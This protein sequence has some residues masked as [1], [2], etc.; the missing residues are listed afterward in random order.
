MESPKVIGRT[1]DQ[2]DDIRAETAHAQT[3]VR[4]FHGGANGE[5]SVSLFRSLDDEDR[6]GVV[7]RITVRD[8]EQCFMPTARLIEG[9]VDLHMAGDTEASNLMLSLR[10]LLAAAN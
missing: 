9:G 1:E 3:V 5:I 7:L 4:Q 6:G 2:D 10:E 8:Q